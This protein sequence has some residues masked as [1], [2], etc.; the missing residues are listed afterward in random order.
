MPNTDQ[1]KQFLPC[2]N[3]IL[4]RPG[5]N[6]HTFRTKLNKTCKSEFLI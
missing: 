3:E 2:L 4:F 6:E 1:E 5:K